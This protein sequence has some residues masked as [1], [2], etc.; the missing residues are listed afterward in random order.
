MP[1][2]ILLDV[3]MPGMSGYDV[4]RRLKAEPELCDIPVIFVTALDD[5][6]DEAFGLQLGA[7]DY[8]VK[9]V[10]PGIVMARVKSQLALKNERDL[11]ESQNAW[12]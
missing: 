3:M 6:A 10:V 2:L 1:D 4:C 5:H 8:I 12:L 7:V 9:P 11:L